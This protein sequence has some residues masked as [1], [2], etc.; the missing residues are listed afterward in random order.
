MAKINFYLVGDCYIYKQEQMKLKDAMMLSR[1]AKINKSIAAYYKDRYYIYYRY[2]INYKKGL[3]KRERDS[4]VALPRSLPS[5]FACSLAVA[6][7]GDDQI[8]LMG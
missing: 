2:I 3:K 6:R 1:I 5:L 4:C 7:S 8:G